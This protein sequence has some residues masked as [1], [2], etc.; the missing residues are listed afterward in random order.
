MTTPSECFV[1]HVK[2]NTC[3]A[4]NMFIMSVILLLPLIV[5]MA[6]F[7]SLPSIDHNSSETVV[8]DRIALIFTGA[9]GS[10][11][12]TLI[13]D[14]LFAIPFLKCFYKEVFK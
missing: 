1:K 7:F 8:F 6:Y 11:F 2:K 10:F 5:F 3:S 14:W 12:V 9:V 13:Y 4:F